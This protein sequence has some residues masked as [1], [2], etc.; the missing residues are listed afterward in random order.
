[1]CF[2]GLLN[3]A[4]KFGNVVLHIASDLLLLKNKVLLRK[5]MDIQFA[6]YSL[7]LLCGKNSSPDGC[8]ERPQKRL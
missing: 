3:V 7:Q 2:G 4:Y 8:E 5:C 6:L 1:M